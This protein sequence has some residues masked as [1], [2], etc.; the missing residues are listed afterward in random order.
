M[1]RQISS[2]NL[3]TADGHFSGPYTLSNGNSLGKD[4]VNEVKSCF[5]E[6][7][8]WYWHRIRNYKITL[9]FSVLLFNF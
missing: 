1:Q 9:L 3:M 4:I 6:V 2:N 7:K 8:T 5:D